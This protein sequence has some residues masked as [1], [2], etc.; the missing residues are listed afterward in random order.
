MYQSNE[1]SNIVIPSPKFFIFC[2]FVHLVSAK[3]NL[4]IYPCKQFVIV[5]MLYYQISPQNL[6]S[7]IF[8]ANQKPKIN[9][10]REI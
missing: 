1:K 4:L 3:F 5:S 8:E 6:F 9:P 7:R 2:E 10:N